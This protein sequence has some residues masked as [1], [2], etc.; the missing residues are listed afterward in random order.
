[1]T[2]H[3]ANVVYSVYFSIIRKEGYFKA[4]PIEEKYK[5]D[6]AF[7]HHM[8]DMGKILT[9][10]SFFFFLFPRDVQVVVERLFS[11]RP[12]EWDLAGLLNLIMIAGMGFDEDT[13]YLHVI[14]ELY[15]TE[16]ESPL[17][18]ST[19]NLGTML[20]GMTLDDVSKTSK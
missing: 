2:E 20:F 3:G 1:M 10:T 6:L 14:T 13:Y 19:Q 16:N 18:A 4:L 7:L 5:Q 9:K 15:R 8:C 17:F 12:L 11:H